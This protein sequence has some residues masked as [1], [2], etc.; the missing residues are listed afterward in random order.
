[1]ADGVEIADIARDR[2]TKILRPIWGFDWDVV[3]KCF[4]IL[5]NGQ[6]E[7]YQDRVNLVIE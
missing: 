2:K 5:I 7:G 1:M 3:H 4:V 6:G